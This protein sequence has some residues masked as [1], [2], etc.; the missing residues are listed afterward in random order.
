[1]IFDR[2]DHG[3]NSHGEGCGVV[4]D[5]SLCSSRVRPEAREHEK[6]YTTE[7]SGYFRGVKGTVVFFDASDGEN[8]DVERRHRRQLYLF[9]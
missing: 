9:P 4:V 7:W 3:R 8:S 6:V 1:V 2:V 5:C